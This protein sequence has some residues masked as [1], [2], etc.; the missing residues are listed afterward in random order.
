MTIAPIPWP[1]NIKLADVVDALDDLAEQVAANTR[2]LD[3]ALADRDAT[4]TQLQEDLE[5]HRAGAAERQAEI[6]RLRA[7]LHRQAFAQRTGRK[8]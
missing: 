8:L 2:R 4:I 7:D 1:K 3:A 5:E 6:D